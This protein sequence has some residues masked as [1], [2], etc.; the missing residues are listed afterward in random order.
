MLKIN[1]QDD[2]YLYNNVSNYQ[3]GFLSSQF[4]P[5]SLWM[6]IVLL[7]NC[8]HV[9]ILQFQFIAI[10]STNLDDL[11][12]KAEKKTGRKKQRRKRG[13]TEQSKQSR[14]RRKGRYCL[15]QHKHRFII[16]EWRPMPE[17][18]NHLPVFRWKS[19]RPLFLFPPLELL[20]HQWGTPKT[21]T[22]PPVPLGVLLGQGA[23]W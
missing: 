21:Q 6:E 14:G 8:N 16:T 12:D 5:A 13:S 4:V 17:T 23:G 18:Q 15:N 1:N 9:T 7:S 22:Q 3:Y 10:N 11:S 2:C 19:C 20:S